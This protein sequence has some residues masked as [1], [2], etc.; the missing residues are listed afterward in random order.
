M[1]SLKPDGHG[2]EDVE[3]DEAAVS[4]VV[5][6][7]VSMAQSLKRHCIFNAL[8]QRQEHL[9]FS[10]GKLISFKALLTWIQ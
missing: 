5:S 10:E 7:K 8:V 4:H 1:E 9:F 2:A 3:E 6:Q